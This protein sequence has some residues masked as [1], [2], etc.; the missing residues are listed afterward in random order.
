MIPTSLL[1]LGCYFLVGVERVKGEVCIV[2][3][4]LLFLLHCVVLPLAGIMGDQRC[5]KEDKEES[6]R[7]E[8]RGGTANVV[9]RQ[10]GI[11]DWT[12][13]GKSAAKVS[14]MSNKSNNIGTIIVILAT[15]HVLATAIVNDGGGTEVEDGH[16]FSLSTNRSR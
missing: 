9:G 15:Y 8:G 11:S 12:I 13:S 14:C 6:K 10:E 1:F 3:L 5:D 16:N 4:S 2:P 7:N